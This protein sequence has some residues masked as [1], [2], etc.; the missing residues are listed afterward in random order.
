M[1]V[2]KNV[3]Q[4]TAF[5]IS[6][7]RAIRLIFSYIVLISQAFFVLSITDYDFH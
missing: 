1:Y 3:H 6:L 5:N 2:A 4:D 7:S